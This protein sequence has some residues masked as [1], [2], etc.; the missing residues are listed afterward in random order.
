M[1][2]VTEGLGVSVDLTA[3][4]KAWLDAIAEPAEQDEAPQRARKMQMQN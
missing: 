4:G 1:S 2:F 3:F